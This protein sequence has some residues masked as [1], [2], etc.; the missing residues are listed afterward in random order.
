MSLRLLDLFSGAGGMARGLQ[1]AGFYVVGI[2]NRLMRRYGGDEFY[3]DDALDVLR[4]LLARET[5]QGY[6]L[7][8]F[9]AIHASPPCQFASGTLKL[10]GREHPNLI[11]ATRR[12]LK[13]SGLP[14]VIENVPGA[15]LVD[16]F[17]LEGQMF[18]GLRTQRPRLFETSWPVRV[19]F[20]RRPQPAPNA[21]MGRV[22]KDHEWMHVVG[23]F[24][25]VAAAREAMGIDWM[26][27]DELAQAIPPT[28][29]EFVGT[30][31]MAHL[32]T[33]LAA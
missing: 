7:R 1:Q 3:Q 14:Y 21:K 30:Q 12:L 18:R 29:G 13:A 6:V 32:A 4:R 15:P 20:E 22:P 5:W 2:D 31:L 17:V 10:W 23:H 25:G 11:P 26:T 16:P 33:S 8:D 24:S 19:P 28:Y 9:V 27:R